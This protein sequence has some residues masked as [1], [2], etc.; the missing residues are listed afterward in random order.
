[1]S[2]W[3][4]KAGRGWK[5]H[6]QYFMLFQRLSGS[7][8]WGSGAPETDAEAA[9]VRGVVA[10]ECHTQEVPAAVVP[11]AAPPHLVRSSGWS[12]RV[13]RGRTAVIGAR[14]PVVDPF[15]DIASQ[16]QRTIRAGPAR[17]AAHGAGIADTGAV[18][19]EVSQRA[20]GGLVSPRKQRRAAGTAGGFLPLGLAGQTL[21]GPA[22]VV[23]GVVPGDIDD[24][25]VGEGQVAVIGC[26][27]VGRKIIGRDSRPDR[28]ALGILGV[29]D[30]VLVDAVGVQIDRVQ[31]QF[32]AG[33][34]RTAV[35]GTVAAI[36]TLPAGTETISPGFSK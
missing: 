12:G 34:A 35:V 20:G 14:P 8:S 7:I 24:R 23:A 18:V 5:T 13:V 32:G 16:V 27:R 26:S 30:F 6:F 25:E 28:H 19:I 31:R 9:D 21:V 36:W 15:P 17:V 1:M 10:A 33:T 3:K 2:H 22:T 11:R 29:G 4:K